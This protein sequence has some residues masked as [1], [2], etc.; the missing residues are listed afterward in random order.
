MK[1]NCEIIEDLLPLYVENLTSKSS[2]ILIEEHLKECSECQKSL[3]SLK[4]TV[5][6]PMNSDINAL[7]KI[8]SQIKRTKIYI[9]TLCTLIFIYF[10]LLFCSFLLEPDYIQHD[11][12]L[13]QIQETDDKVT[14]NFNNLDNQYMPKVHVVEA[15][16]FS[17]LVD[18]EYQVYLTFYS[19]SF[20]EALMDKPVTSFTVDKTNAEHLNLSQIYYSYPGDEA[21]LIWGESINGG[22]TLLPRLIHNFYIVLSLALGFVGLGTSFIFVKQER[23]KKYTIT[24]L[25]ITAIPI[26]LSTSLMLVTTLQS[27]YT[28]SIDFTIALLMSAVMYIGLFCTIN[29]FSKLLHN[30]T[31]I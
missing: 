6:L 24:V 18:N 10:S 22:T 1:N 9:I 30:K 21:M 25:K 4:D 26:S 13:Y 2:N 11:N 8:K 17:N 15:E 12:L 28:L 23:L 14:F 19:T 3:A 5:H 16:T 27:S 29:F 31:T 7:K 20:H